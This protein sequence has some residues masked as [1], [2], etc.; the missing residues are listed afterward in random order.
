MGEESEI[1]IAPPPA[2]HEQE[3]DEWAWKP[4]EELPGLIVPFKRA[5]YDRVVAEFRHLSG[6]TV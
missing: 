1:Q 6:T 2:G 5:V 4:M 3:F